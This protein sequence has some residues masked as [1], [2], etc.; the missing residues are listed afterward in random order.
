MQANSPISKVRSL[1]ERVGSSFSLSLF[2]VFAWR[3]RWAHS[4]RSGANPYL[5]RQGHD[6]REAIF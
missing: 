1:G 5:N 6:T 4:E 2:P 3:V